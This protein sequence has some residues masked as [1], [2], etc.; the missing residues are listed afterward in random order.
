MLFA[1]MEDETRHAY[2]YACRA[3]RRACR[4]ERSARP[5]A[6][7][8]P[9]GLSGSLH[10]PGRMTTHV[11]RL[12]ASQPHWLLS[13][14]R[15]P[16]RASS[17]ASV[18]TGPASAEGLRDTL[19]R[20]RTTTTSTF[21]ASSRS[22]SSSSSPS[23]RPWSR[24]TPSG[25]SWEPSFSAFSP[26]PQGA[27][28]LVNGLGLAI[29][30]RPKRSPSSTFPNPCPAQ[31]T[32]LVVVPTLLLKESQVQELFEDVEA[33]YLSN[34]DP[35]IHFRAPDRPRRLRRPS[36]LPTKRQ[37]AGQ[38]GHRVHPQSEREVRRWPRRSLHPPAS[39]P[40]LQRPPGRLDGL[41]AQARQAP[42]PEQAPPRRVRQLPHQDRPARS[43]AEIRPLR[44]HARLRH[45]AS[46]R[47][48]RPHDRH[49]RPPAQSA[50]S[51]THGSASSPQDMAS[52]NRASESASPRPRVPGSPPSTP[53]RPASTSTRAPSRTSIRTSSA[54]ASSPARASTRSASSTRCSSAAFRAM[55][56]SR[57]T[58]SKAP[59][60]APAWSR[61][62]R[63]ST[64][65]PLNTHAHT[66]RKHRWIRGDWQ[67]LR[68]LFLNVPDESGRLGP[69]SHQLHLP[70]EDP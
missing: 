13:L 63:S 44:H 46:A 16:A 17:S 52:C 58:S 47:H 32:T 8:L 60:S 56:C 54:K 39:L 15:R 1:G 67:I 48:R 33:R 61:T 12:N 27:V 64:T 30:A 20:G 38:D 2:H 37:P 25:R 5:H 28:D 42:R 68:W 51:S 35:N 50:P 34:E 21:S 69:Q 22:P 23:L 9:S 26:S 57:M 11:S 40:R 14:R 7:P 70:V 49:H 24:T 62:S 53:A 29:P 59:T 18:I 36:P 19:S 6:P 3:S 43:R 31:A 45:P 65:I 55:R 41:G 66:R 10:S 4:H